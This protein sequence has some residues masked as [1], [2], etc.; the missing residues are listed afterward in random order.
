MNIHSNI[1]DLEITFVKKFYYHPKMCGSSSI[2]K[3]L[4]AIVL[5]FKDVYVNLN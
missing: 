5:N 4:P 1:K 2:K 3:V